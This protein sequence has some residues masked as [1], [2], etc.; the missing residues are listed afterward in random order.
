LRKLYRWR[1][2]D[3]GS[4]GEEAAMRMKQSL[5]GVLAAAAVGAAAVGSAGCGATATVDPV[6]QAAVA[7]QQLPGARVRMTE[8]LTSAALPQ[9]VTMTGTGFLN[10]RERSGQ[11]TFDFS[12]FPGI[13]SLPGSKTAEMRFAFP[14][15]YMKLGFLANQLPGHKA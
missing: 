13:S 10:Q 4:N 6:A 12:H 5:V 2:G 1:R 8:Q 3:D 15:I 9:P 14:V 7:T 11:L